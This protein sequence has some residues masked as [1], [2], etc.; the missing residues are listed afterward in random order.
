[1]SQRHHDTLAPHA[2][3]ER[4]RT[5]RAVRHEVAEVLATTPVDEL[6]DV[7]L[8]AVVRTVP[9]QAPERARRREHRHWKLPFWKRR[10]RYRA[11]KLAADG[12]AV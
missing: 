10:D 7:V 4:R 3:D 9:H 5:R 8:P 2:K 12:A 11:A 1:M 6:D